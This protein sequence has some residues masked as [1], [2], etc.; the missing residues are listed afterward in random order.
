[1]VT[2][3]V[4]STSGSDHS[5]CVTETMVTVP[6]ECV[7]AARSASDVQST[8]SVT[9]VPGV[10]P[11]T[12]DCDTYLQQTT[13]AVDAVFVSDTAVPSASYLI[14]ATVLLTQQLHF[15]LSVQLPQG[16]PLMFSLLNMLLNCQ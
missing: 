14:A 2:T 4:P 11:S 9:T 7:A 5:D 12:S 6:A 10:I 8:S 13:S 16:L 1:M 15:L 3:A